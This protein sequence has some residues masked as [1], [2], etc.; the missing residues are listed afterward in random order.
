MYESVV[1]YCQSCPVFA[2]INSPITSHRM[3]LNCSFKSLY[4]TV[5]A[6]ALQYTH[7][8]EKRNCSIRIHKLTRSTMQ[9]A[10]TFEGY[11]MRTFFLH[12]KHI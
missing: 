6:F 2:K 1:S 10:L 4:A 8:Y 12:R 7:M 9:D 3:V 11:I 5:Y